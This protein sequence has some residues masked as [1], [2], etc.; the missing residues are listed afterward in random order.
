LLEDE[1]A[2][3]VFE[4]QRR[5]TPRTGTRVPRPP[6]I[7][8]LLQCLPGPDCANSK[9]VED[10]A[11]GALAVRHRDPGLVDAALELQDLAV[12]I[13]EAIAVSRPTA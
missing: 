11:G 7:K 1:V 8:G 10:L 5:V 9:D 4:F 6:V 3:R 2:W 12:S 13:P